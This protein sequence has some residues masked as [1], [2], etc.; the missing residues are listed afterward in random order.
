[1]IKKLDSCK[2]IKLDA[3]PAGRK[4]YNKLG[5]ADEYAIARLTT[6]N[7]V[8]PSILKSE[9]ELKEFTQSKL[10]EVVLYDKKAFG[11]D[12]G[13]VL[14]FLLDN[15]AVKAWCLE[16]GGKIEGYILS[17]PGCNF[18][19]VGPV[20]AKSLENAKALLSSVF[21]KMEGQPVVIDVMEN[22]QELLIWM[23]ELNFTV[24][25]SFTRM[26]LKSN[27]YAGNPEQQFLIG[28]PELG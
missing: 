25:R 10:K 18:T 23:Q 20:V 12:R 13:K 17:R 14:K 5:F 21:V 22:N 2:S 4:V 28:G 9:F 26:Y 8:S 3:T 11:V 1:M 27:S 7:L 19:Q 24:Q 16:D 15:Q 6:Q